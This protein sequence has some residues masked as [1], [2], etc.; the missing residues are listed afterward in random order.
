MKPRTVVLALLFAILVAPSVFAQNAAFEAALQQAKAENKG[1][2]IYFHADGFNAPEVLE[3]FMPDDWTVKT[4]LERRYIAI[5]VDAD[6]EAGKALAGR[7]PSLGIYPVLALMDNSG[8]LKAHQIFDSGQ[9]DAKTW[10]HFF[11]KHELMVGEL[12]GD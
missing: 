1:I 3:D 11:L 12:K 6:T 7:F 10:A 8:E 2:A 9:E 4:F 5:S